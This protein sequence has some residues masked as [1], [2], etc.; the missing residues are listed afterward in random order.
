ME[1]W[2]MLRCGTAERLVSGPMLGRNGWRAG[3]AGSAGE[4]SQGI[5]FK[6]QTPKSR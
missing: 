3:L 5:D 4:N 6:G 1:D 2:G